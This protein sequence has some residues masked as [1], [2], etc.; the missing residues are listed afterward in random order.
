MEVKREN[1]QIWPVSSFR[2]AGRLSGRLRGALSDV[3]EIERS[4]NGI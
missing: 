1:A 2:A 3:R 4:L